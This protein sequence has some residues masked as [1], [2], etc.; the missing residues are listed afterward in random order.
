MRRINPIWLSG[1]RDKIDEAVK[2]NTVYTLTVSVAIA[3]TAIVASLVNRKVPFV[4][5]NMGAGVA[6]ITTS[7]DK[8]PF[9]GKNTKVAE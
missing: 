5:K 4:M 6:V 9:C 3:K 8:C 2:N 1:E 7:T